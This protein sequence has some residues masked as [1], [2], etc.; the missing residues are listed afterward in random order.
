MRIVQ[1]ITTSQSFIISPRASVNRLKITDKETNVSD[2]LNVTSVVGSYHTT[3]TFA[4]S[5][6]VEGHIYRIELYDTT[7]T[8]PI[9]YKGLMLATANE[10]DY[11]LNKNYYTQNTTTN[12]FTILE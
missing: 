4:Y 5:K 6:L 10:S 12:E 7:L 2:I 3:V 9:L 1:P 8:T 11:S